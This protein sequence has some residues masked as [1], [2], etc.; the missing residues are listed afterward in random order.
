MNLLVSLAWPNVA[1]TQFFF[2][3]VCV[4]QLMAFRSCHLK[5]GLMLEHNY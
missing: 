3:E 2:E 1:A 5:L 4:M